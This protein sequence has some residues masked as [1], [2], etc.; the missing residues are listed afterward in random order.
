MYACL[1]KVLQADGAA[2]ASMLENS[3]E[4]ER[5]IKVGLEDVRDKS[6]ESSS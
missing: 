1:Q 3:A 2:S 4:F 5:W 6:T